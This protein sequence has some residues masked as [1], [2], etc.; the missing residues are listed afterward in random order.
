MITSLSNNKIFT[1]NVLK[2]IAL[3]CMTI[4]HVGEMFFPSAVWMRIAGRLAF[5]IFAFMI[6][7]GCRYTKNKAR[8]LGI[9]ASMALVMQIIY[10]VFEKSLYMCIF[11]TFSFSVSLI[12]A[13]D[14]FIKKKNFT[15]FILAFGVVTGIFYL[16]KILPKTTCF[17]VDYGF[18]GV[19]LPVAVY[20]FK[21]FWGKIIAFSLML[22]LISI[23][24]R[25]VQLYSLFAVILIML[26]NGKRG[27]MNLKYLFYVYY[28]LHLAVIY[29]IYLIL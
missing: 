7:E 25:G 16:T 27:R 5:P 26:Y 17:G 14:Y 23:D 12:Y 29:V 10:F 19:M 21:G 8:Y 9:M 3:V 18:F 11:V 4:D 24:L 22:L 20:Y 13:I 1:G 2:I 15:S 6:S 28:P